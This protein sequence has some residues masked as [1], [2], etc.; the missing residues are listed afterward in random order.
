[1]IAVAKRR[2]FEGYR[3]QL[4]G[5]ISSVAGFAQALDFPSD[6]SS[7]SL[8]GLAVKATFRKYAWQDYPTVTLA[9]TASQIVI[10]DADTLTFAAT[11]SDMSS[12]D[13]G[14]Y[15]FDITTNS[16]GVISHLAQGQV[17]VRSS[18]VSW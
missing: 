6:G 8:T 13:E 16:T 17:M 2:R 1:M 4:T 12:L 3:Y 10:T 14:L 15:T 18:P 9:S 11:A 7:L 5:E